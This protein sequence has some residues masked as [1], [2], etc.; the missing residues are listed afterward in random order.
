MS[1]VVYKDTKSRILRCITKLKTFA[2]ASFEYNNE[3]RSAGKLVKIAK[4][5]TELTPLRNAVEEDIQRME[6]AVNSHTAPA[7]I[8]D[9]S[10]SQA[11]ITSFDGLH[12]E[13]AGFTDVHKFKEW[14]SF[15]DLFTSIL[16]HAPELPDVERFEFL[17]MSL[18][19][20]ALTLVSHLMLTTTNY[21]S[22]WKILRSRYGNKRDLAHVH[23]DSLLAT[24]IV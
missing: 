17:K 1:D 20:E 22:A 10:E 4:M 19:D 2:Q 16:S 8:T 12:Y 23:L 13:L 9:T 7:A 15:E 6:S 14:Q 18:T 5:I 21:T 3:R 11:L 24:Q